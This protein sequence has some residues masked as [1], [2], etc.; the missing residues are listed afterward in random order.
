MKDRANG[1]SKNL[2]G[3][4]KFCFWCQQDF[5]SG[6]ERSKCVN[7]FSLKLCTY[8]FV[9]SKLANTYVCTFNV[10][11]YLP[12]NNQVKTMLYITRLRSGS[13]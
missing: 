7:E 10:F 1:G 13:E 4:N 12:R 2:N 3:T 6:P 9:N 8:V 5:G 11:V